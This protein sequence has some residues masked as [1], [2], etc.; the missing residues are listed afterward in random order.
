MLK[1]QPL[2]TKSEYK[3]HTATIVFSYYRGSTVASSIDF[4]SNGSLSRVERFPVRAHRG[5]RYTIIYGVIE[6]AHIG[7]M[8]GSKLSRLRIFRW[9]VQKRLDDPKFL[10]RLEQYEAG[11]AYREALEAVSDARKLLVSTKADLAVAVE[12]IVRVKKEKPKHF[13]IPLIK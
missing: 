12:E 13:T 3:G 11:A 4:R 5:H 1:T 7:Y 2:K 8:G 6:N 9:L 10:K